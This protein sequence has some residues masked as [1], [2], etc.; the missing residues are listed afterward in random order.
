[1]KVKWHHDYN[2][3]KMTLK[4]KELIRMLKLGAKFELAPAYRITYDKDG[5]KKKVELMH[6]SL[7]LVN[8]L[9]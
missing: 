9:R 6:V 5:N 1:M 7:S 3:G 8:D 2:I 4:S